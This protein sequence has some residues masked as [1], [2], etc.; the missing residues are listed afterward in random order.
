MWSENIKKSGI[1]GLRLNT[2]RISA[3]LSSYFHKYTFIKVQLFIRNEFQP[4]DTKQNYS[5]DAVFLLLIFMT[6]FWNVQNPRANTQ[7]INEIVNLHAL[8][9]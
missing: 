4:L 7:N 8:T 5:Y 2:E 9:H 1:M 3:M 6:S